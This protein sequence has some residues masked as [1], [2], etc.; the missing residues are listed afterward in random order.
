MS[1]QKSTS[2]T[3]LGRVGSTPP[4]TQTFHNLLR[5]FGESIGLEGLE[6]EQ[7]RC[8][9]L[10]GEGSEAVQLTMEV[11]PDGSLC[12]YTILDKNPDGMPQNIKDLVATG[13]EDGT[14]LSLNSTATTL[15]ICL[16]S[17]I[18]NSLDFE[19][20]VRNFY[21]SVQEWRRRYE[22]LARPL[23]ASTA[24]LHKPTKLKM[25]RYLD[26]ATGFLAI[27]YIIYRMGGILA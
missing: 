26:K 15:F 7:N 11:A 22:H 24:L 20:L 25:D 4:Q 19:T 2:F 5:E 9:L 3:G 8:S 27:A 16:N 12:F 6:L 17:Q 21:A 13:S 1:L 18:T 10:L 14:Y 23:P